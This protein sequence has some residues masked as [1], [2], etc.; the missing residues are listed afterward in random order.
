MVQIRDCTM[1]WT[2]KRLAVVFGLFVAVFVS[3]LSLTPRAGAQEAKPSLLFVIDTSGSMDAA[4][5]GGLTRIQSARKAL[6]EVVVG[7][8]GSADVGLRSFA[9]GCGPGRL[10]V[11]VGPLNKAV[12]K[13]NVDGLFSAG[14]TPIDAVLRASIKDL[15]LT[16]KR[17]IVLLS[18]GEETCGGSPCLAVKEILKSGI[19]VTINTIGFATSGTGAEPELQCIA[20]ASG[21]KYFPVESASSLAAALIE[22]SKPTT[23]TPKVV[24]VVP[25]T[26]VAPATTTSTTTTTTT[27][28]PIVLP[29]Y[30]TLKNMIAVGDSYSSGE[31][32]TGVPSEKYEPESALFP[33][34]CH[35]SLA[36]YHKLIKGAMPQASYVNGTCSGATIDRYPN[37]RA[38][39]DVVKEQLQLVGGG[40]NADLVTASMGGNDAKFGAIIGSCIGSWALRKFLDNYNIKPLDARAVGGIAS[41]LSEEGLGCKALAELA[42][43]VDDAVAK[44]E[45]RVT[46]GFVSLAQEAPNALILGLNYPNPVPPVIA[47]ASCSGILAQDAKY[48]DALIN[49]INAIET[50]AQTAVSGVVP[51]DVSTAFRNHELCSANPFINGLA[52]ADLDKLYNQISALANP[53]VDKLAD[54]WGEV[55]NCFLLRAAAAPVPFVDGCSD[56]DYTK[57]KNA[58]KAQA[59]VIAALPNTKQFIT[60]VETFVV[61]DQRNNLFHPSDQGHKQMACIVSPAIQLSLPCADPNSLKAP[62]SPP[63]NPNKKS[64]TIGAKDVTVGYGGTDIRINPSVEFSVDSSGWFPS[65][66]VKIN[67]FSEPVT[68][69]TLKADATGRI[70][71]FLRLPANFPPGHHRL[72]L[73]GSAP[74]G[75]QQSYERIVFVPGTPKFGD[76]YGTYVQG[77]TPGEEVTVTYG[78]ETFRYGADS[79]GGVLFSAPAVDSTMVFVA[80]SVGSRT[81]ASKLNANNVTG[82]A[83][84]GSVPA[85]G[86][87]AVSPEGTLSSAQS[88]TSTTSTTSPASDSGAQSTS[89]PA[90]APAPA[91]AISVE[92]RFAG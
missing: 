77:F 2:V 24:V 33:F 90:V 81:V 45:G 41:S 11:P 47:G 32:S 12:F 14:L 28:T 22:T 53:E 13:T 84:N 8:D 38:Q 1:R 58:L 40:R 42:F 9:G 62:F 34:R 74:D 68:L 46:S 89:V 80:K 26:T 61:P 86:S 3:G 29:L 76:D 78:K 23:E 52:N 57:Y 37:T 5:Q 54:R 82:A 83:P 85:S 50:R 69:G 64:I 73:E 4:A 75:S 25:A 21:G 39:A 7:L 65:F 6:N 72:V 30:K 88:A 35:R 92:P 63:A 15:P 20:T 43:N 66:D 44:L 18:D 51:V 59:A 79:S 10:L 19:S 56:S 67:I 17:T 60:I 16:G 27:T 91:Q 36:A 49:S 87:A 71:G 70:D 31:G 48:L 55:R